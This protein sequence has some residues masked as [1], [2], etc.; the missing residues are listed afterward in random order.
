MFHAPY[1]I[2]LVKF[3]TSENATDNAKQIYKSYLS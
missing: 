1:C 3:I 2:I